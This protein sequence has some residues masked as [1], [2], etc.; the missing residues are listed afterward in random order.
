LSDNRII[1]IAGNPVSNYAELDDMKLI[2]DYIAEFSGV[3]LAGVT[4]NDSFIVSGSQKGNT[5]ELFLINPYTRLSRRL[6]D[7][8]FW[9]DPIFRG[10]SS[11]GFLAVEATDIED[12]SRNIY[13]LDSEGNL[14]QTVMNSQ[15][16]IWIP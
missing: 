3:V 8:V 13:I 1:P 2:P 4:M 14:V 6:G 9:I 12:D 15:M 11:D 10:E 7:E 5:E 16:P